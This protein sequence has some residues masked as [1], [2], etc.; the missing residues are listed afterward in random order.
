MNRGPAQTESEFCAAAAP[1]L[2][3]SSLRKPN[4][5]QFCLFALTSKS[6]EV[7]SQFNKYTQLHCSSEAPLSRP[8]NLPGSLSG[9]PVSHRLTLL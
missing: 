8:P 2:E 1:R 5:R 9:T 3:A 4:A 6:P 7:P